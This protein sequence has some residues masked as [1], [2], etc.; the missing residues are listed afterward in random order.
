MEVPELAGRG[1]AGHR[2]DE[3]ERRC[4]L[5]GHQLAE[6]E[7]QAATEA[8]CHVARAAQLPPRRRCL[9]KPLLS[10]LPYARSPHDG[11]NARGLPGACMTRPSGSLVCYGISLWTP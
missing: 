10:P 3:Q 9:D 7:H 6:P 11:Q 2:E 8:E 4:H 1:H 5:G